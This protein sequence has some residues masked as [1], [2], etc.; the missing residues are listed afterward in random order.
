MGQTENKYQDRLK[1]NHI[2]D[3]IQNKVNN[4]LKDRDR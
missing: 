1:L 2:N 4:Q 3:H